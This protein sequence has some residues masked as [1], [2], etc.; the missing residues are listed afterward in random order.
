[1]QPSRSWKNFSNFIFLNIKLF[2]I[3]FSLNVTFYVVFMFFVPYCMLT[4]ARGSLLCYMLQKLFTVILLIFSLFSLIF[5]GMSTWFCF[6][7]L[8][9]TA[10]SIY[11]G[12]YIVFVPGYNVGFFCTVMPSML[13]CSLLPDSFG[14]ASMREFWLYRLVYLCFVSC[15][16]CKL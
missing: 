9:C 2:K 15:I 3:L 13:L 11:V 16:I 1:M 10:Y 4:F 7:P 14:T 5:L 8:G 6:P 12:V